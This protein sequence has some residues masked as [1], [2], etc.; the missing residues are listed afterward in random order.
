MGKKI[1]IT[2]IVL[3]IVCAG[4]YFRAGLASIAG[5][6]A[7]ALFSNKRKPVDGTKADAD[8]QAADA[9][10]ANRA[11]VGGMDIVSQSGEGIRESGERLVETGDGLVES[12][13]SIIDELRKCDETANN[14]P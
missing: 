7:V 4:I 2:I 6:I 1:A 14:N 5:L 10:R 8:R 11:A 3:L 13:Q 9:E 12:S